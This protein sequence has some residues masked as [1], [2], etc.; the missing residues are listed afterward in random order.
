MLSVVWKLEYFRGGHLHIHVEGVPV[1]SVSDVY[2]AC[3]SPV[4][5][6]MPVHPPHFKYAARFADSMHSAHQFSCFEWFPV[7]S[8]VVDRHNFTTKFE[9]TRQ[10]S[11]LILSVWLHWQ[12]LIVKPDPRNPGISKRLLGLQQVFERRRHEFAIGIDAEV[13]FRS[14]LPFSAAFRSWSAR[15]EVLAAKI[16]GSDAHCSAQATIARASCGAVGLPSPAF[17]YWWLDVPIYERHDFGSFLAAYKWSR[18]GY[19]TFCHFSYLCWKLGVANWTIRDIA[20]TIPNACRGTDHLPIR[21]QETLSQRLKWS[22]M[23]AVGPS[24][25]GTRLLRYHLDRHFHS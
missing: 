11:S 3:L 12:P 19:H 14:E 13:E 6:V 15:R 24:R 18:L 5:I 17:F 20:P 4:A 25:G 21:I 7:F 1:Q 22:F 16:N 2:M 10:N 9:S 8:T 23:W